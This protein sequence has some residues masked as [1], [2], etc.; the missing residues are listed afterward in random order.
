V[1]RVQ[2]VQVQQVEGSQVPHV[3]RVQQVPVQQLSQVR[4]VLVGGCG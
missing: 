3:A 1:A 4:R 2:R